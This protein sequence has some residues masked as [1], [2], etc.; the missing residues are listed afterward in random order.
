LS[1]HAML[2]VGYIGR[3]IRN[4]WQ[5]I[6]IDAV[7]YMTTLG[8]QS[9]AQAFAQTY[10][11]VS[12]AG[13]SNVSVSPQPFLESA[14]GGANSTFCRGFAS[15]TAAVANNGTMSGLIQNNQV[16]QLW[17]ALNGA[18]SWTLGRTMPSSASPAIPAGQLSAVYYDT[19]N[20]FGNYNGAYF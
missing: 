20:G 6:D 12:A 3:I 5:Q 10:F 19:S 11:A 18:S 14:L 7:P 8:G 9:F 15:C 16:Y 4:E 17:A 1:S 2:E 13:G